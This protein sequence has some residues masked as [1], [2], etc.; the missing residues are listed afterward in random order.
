MTG[1]ETL[2]FVPV[3]A[4]ETFSVPNRFVSTKLQL[5]GEFSGVSIELPAG[6]WPAHVTEGPS[7]TV[8]ELPI[9]WRRTGQDVAGKAVK[10]GPDGIEFD[11]PITISVPVDPNTDLAGYH[12]RVFKYHPSS[13][14]TPESWTQKEMP[15]GYKV[16]DQP[17]IIK[18]VTKSFSVYVAVKVP[19]DASQEASA[20]APAPNTG[21]PKELVSSDTTVA[22]KKSSWFNTTR[23]VAIAMSA[24]VLFCAA[25][26]AAAVLCNK[27]MKK[28][29]Q[30]I[31]PASQ[32]IIDIELTQALEDTNGV[33]CSAC[34]AGVIEG[35]EGTKSCH[36]CGAP[37]V[38]ND[39]IIQHVDDNEMMISDRGVTLTGSDIQD[40]Q[41]LAVSTGAKMQV[42]LVFPSRSAGPLSEVEKPVFKSW[43]IAA[44]DLPELEYHEDAPT[45]FVEVGRK[46]QKQGYSL[47]GPAAPVTEQKMAN[48]DTKDFLPPHMISAQL[49]THGAGYDA[50]L[51]PV[52]RVA[53]AS[54]SAV[55]SLQPSPAASFFDE[56]LAPVEGKIMTIQI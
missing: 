8:F 28:R 42:Q 7:L 34:E 3:F 15:D 41:E 27:R 4:R 25:A 13:G 6:A 48:D 33:F 16:P 52:P 43:Q 54:A 51:L 56:D 49:D 5:K 35:D 38:H 47:L 26:V 45:S 21:D 10:F 17:S 46:Y 2:G 12:L 30:Q 53:S 36:M 18:G 23:I 24:S 14:T 29:K 40:P 55:H 50:K 19:D 9:S 37:R 44:L 20:A 39:E 32:P 31:S 22:G 1:L 11:V